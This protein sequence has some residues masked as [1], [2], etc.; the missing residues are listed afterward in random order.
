MQSASVMCWIVPSTWLRGC[1]S[2]GTA[3]RIAYAATVSTTTTVLL[4]PPRP[5]ARVAA[6]RWAATAVPLEALVPL[7]LL[8]EHRCMPP[9]AIL[10]P[11]PATT[12]RLPL[13]GRQR[14]R[15][16]RQADVRANQ[17]QD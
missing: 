15:P 10:G 7:H 13:R 11:R 14:T 4:G 5:V 12:A 2:G 3:A 8:D 9:R 17:L 16:A 6:R 1:L